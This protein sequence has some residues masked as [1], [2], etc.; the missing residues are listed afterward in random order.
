MFA[1]SDSAAIETSRNVLYTCLELAL[2][3]TSPLM[4]FLTEELWQRL[5]Q[6][7]G[8]S[9]WPSIMVAEWPEPDKV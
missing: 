3:L 5:P 7:V 1:S 6:R 4:P 2:R 9:Q 8:G